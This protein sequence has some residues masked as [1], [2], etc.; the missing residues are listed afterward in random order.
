MSE[1]GEHQ[2]LSFEEAME[3]LEE[4]VDQLEAGQVPLEEAIT[5]FQK[6]MK[7][8]KVC[9]D[10]LERVEK[11]VQVLLEENGEL[12]RKDFRIEEEARD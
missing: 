11:Q 2:S 9:H 8:S 10:T 3:E 1:T 6:G 12:I 7:L 5:L 4:I